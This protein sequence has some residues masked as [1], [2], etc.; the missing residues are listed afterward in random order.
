M[1]LSEIAFVLDELEADPQQAIERVDAHSKAIESQ[2]ASRRILLRYLTALIRKEIFPMVAINTRHVPARRILSIQRRLRASETDGFVRG[3]RA[4]F[5]EHLGASAPA[6]PFT[7]IFRVVVSNE[8]DGPIEA[9]VECPKATETSDLVG[10]RTE[11]A[12]D[13]VFT[14]I[15]KAQWDYP[16]TLAAYDA[17]AC[18]P[19]AL[20]PPNGRLSYREVYLAEP[21]SLSDDG[22]ICDIAF[23]L[24]DAHV[25]S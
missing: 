4:A 22:L 14:T 21:E 3:A 7:L 17:V 6:G 13:E 9:T 2:H 23:P 18:S 5:A 25:A 24:G 1:S 15:T 8:S 10:V 16:A 11:E 20:A 19:E 12:H